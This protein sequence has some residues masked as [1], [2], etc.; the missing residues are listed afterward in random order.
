M[1][2]IAT[3]PLQITRSRYVVV[4]SV[5]LIVSMLQKDN[6]RERLLRLEPIAVQLL[7]FNILCPFLFC[8]VLRVVLYT[9]PLCAKPGNYFSFI[10]TLFLQNKQL[11]K[12]INKPFMLFVFAEMK[13]RMAHYYT[14]ITW[15]GHFNEAIFVKIF[16]NLDHK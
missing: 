9:K 13:T 3:I 2:T 15:V 12:R 14:K 16:V 11:T 7:P 6:F 4:F 5:F 10:S 1:S 8:T